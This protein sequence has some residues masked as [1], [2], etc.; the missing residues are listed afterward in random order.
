[1]AETIEKRVSEIEQVL[2]HL[3]EDLDARI[4]PFRV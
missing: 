4:R 1:M 3:P 2:A